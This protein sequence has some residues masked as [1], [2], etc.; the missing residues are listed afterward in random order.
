MRCGVESL[1]RSSRSGAASMSLRRSLYMS[2]V[3]DGFHPVSVPARQLF[4]VCDHF[5]TQSRT[6]GRFGTQPGSNRQGQKRNESG[7]SEAA[8]SVMQSKST[9][10]AGVG[11]RATRSVVV[12]LRE[13]VATAFGRHVEET[14]KRVGKIAGAM[15]LL[16]RGRGKGHLGAPEV[17]DRAVLLLEDVEDGLVPVLAIRHAMLGAHSLGEL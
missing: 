2:A 13:E 11:W 7:Q 9:R 10:P 12:H 1:L 6:Q 8:L 4:P 16:G 5:H 17:P 3:C 14:P 15:V